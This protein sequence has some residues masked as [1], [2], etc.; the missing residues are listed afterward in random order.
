M[1]KST[2][3]IACIGDNV[4]AFFICQTFAN[5]FGIMLDI[6]LDIV[7]SYT[8]HYCGALRSFRSFQLWKSVVSSTLSCGS[9][10]FLSGA[11]G[12]EMRAF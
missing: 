11:E 6:P 10:G 3:F 12:F 7:L 1:Y 9:E 4:R 8:V 2:N 5:F